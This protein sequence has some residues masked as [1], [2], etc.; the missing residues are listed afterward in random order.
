MNNLN[1]IDKI[2]KNALEEIKIPSKNNWENLS[3]KMNNNNFS[4][5]NSSSQFFSKMSSFFT[6]KITILV[7]IVIS[8][9]SLSFLFVTQKN[10]SFTNIK[11]KKCINKQIKSTNNRQIVIEN[12]FENEENQINED[13]NNENTN[14]ESII[15]N[16]YPEEKNDSTKTTHVVIKHTNI[17]RDTLKTIDTLKN[18]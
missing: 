18:Q 2:A 17:V 13:I 7:S 11:A 14:I 16:N 10:T 12:T 6:S 9:V 8:V 15:K 4:A 5:N 1:Y 3:E